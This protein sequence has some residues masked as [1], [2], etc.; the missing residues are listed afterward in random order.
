MKITCVYGDKE[1]ADICASLPDAEVAK[2]RL[3]GDHHFNKDY[4]SLGAAVL[5]ASR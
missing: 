2:I 4:A 1:R 5:R 3:P